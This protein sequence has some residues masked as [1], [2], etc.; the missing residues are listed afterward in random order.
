[1]SRSTAVPLAADPGRFA[2]APTA[3]KIG[4]MLRRLSK[5][6][7]VAVFA[8]ALVS[9]AAACPNCKNSLAGKDLDAWYFS[10]V[11]MMSAPFLLVGGGGYY[12]YRLA[13]KAASESAET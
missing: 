12:L 1:M 5:P 4:T 3:D 2:A 13:K 6:A 9:P 10:I 7:L 8:A 11:G